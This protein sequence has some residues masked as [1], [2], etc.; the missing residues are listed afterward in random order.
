MLSL[1]YIDV[2]AI[3]VSDCPKKNDDARANYPAPAQAFAE[4]R[5]SLMS[6]PA[7]A[8]APVCAC[9]PAYLFYVSVISLRPLV[10][11]ILVGS[12]SMISPSRK[13]SS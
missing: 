4:R 3:L 1:F 12:I 6:G 7:P 8:P 5:N 13:L 2:Y 10:H 9:A 11:K